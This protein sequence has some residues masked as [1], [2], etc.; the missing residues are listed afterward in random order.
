MNGHSKSEMPERD[1]RE[2]SIFTPFFTYLTW[3]QRPC[4]STA[5]F[6]GPMKH[7]IEKS[8]SQG[9]RKTGNFS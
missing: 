7:E 4:F 9:A 1:L 8:G 6:N 2:Y 3:L 5:F